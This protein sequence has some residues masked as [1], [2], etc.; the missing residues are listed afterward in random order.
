[1]GIF[2]LLKLSL[3]FVFILDPEFQPSRKLE[4]SNPGFLWPDGLCASFTGADAVLCTGFVV[5][6][7]NLGRLLFLT[8]FPL[9]EMT[10]LH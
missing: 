2:A 1:M 8:F 5:Y 4:L 3:K 10:N 7:L 9:S 6:S